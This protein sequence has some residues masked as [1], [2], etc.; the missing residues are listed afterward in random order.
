MLASHLR[1]RPTDDPV[2]RFGARLARDV[3]TL[4]A[5]DIGVFH[6]YAFATLRQLGASAELSAS[7]LEWLDAGA[8]TTAVHAYRTIADSAKTMQF[9]LARAV[10]RKRAVDMRPLL[11]DMSRAWR[12]A[13]D[14]VVSR[15]DG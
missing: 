4:S 12:T 10:S 13:T 11:E 5:E 8:S 2:A 3:E 14:E 6:R 15:H 1:R 9:Q 7:F